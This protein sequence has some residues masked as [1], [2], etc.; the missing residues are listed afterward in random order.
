MTNDDG[1]KAPGINKLFMYLRDYFD[2]TMIAPS[3]ERSA[4]SHSISLSKE[5]CFTREAERIV[6]V[7]GT[8]TDCVALGV[9]RYLE[10]RPDL[11]ISGIN[12]GPNMG[13]DI[14]Y[15]GTVAAAM[16]GCILGIPSIS[17]S[18]DSKSDFQFDVID[19]Y[20][21]QI[22]ERYLEIRIPEKTFLNINFP[23]I[24]SSE[25]KG[26]YVT[27][28]GKHTYYDNIEVTVNTDDKIVYLNKHAYHKF[29]DIAGTDFWAVDKGYISITPIKLDLTHYSAIEFFKKEFI[30]S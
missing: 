27:N 30:L 4:I 25:I 28:L 18:I 11:V 2:V 29:E 6:S 19:N 8:P 20:L 3:G 13:D 10:S 9:K 22:I 16:E 7:D 23:N 17:I 21:M 1:W 14:T 24:S 5:V 12:L 15:S 26:F